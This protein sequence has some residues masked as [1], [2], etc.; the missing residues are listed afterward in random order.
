VPKVTE[1][2]RLMG[3]SEIAEL[4][5][6]SKQRASVLC[7]KKG[8]PDP[9]QQVIPVDDETR[10]ALVELF[11]KRTGKRTYSAEGTWQLFSD[12]SFV[13]PEAPRLWRQSAVEEWA[14]A[15]GRELIYSSPNEKR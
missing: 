8:F 4:L 13:L 11:T 2:R 1:R 12:G 3:V 7:N 9:V 5:G 6:V 14:R 10:Q 15:H